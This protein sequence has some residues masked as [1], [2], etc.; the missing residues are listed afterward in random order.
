MMVTGEGLDQLD[1]MG[2]VECAG[3]EYSERMVQLP[4]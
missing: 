1:L 4:G 3:H 2:W